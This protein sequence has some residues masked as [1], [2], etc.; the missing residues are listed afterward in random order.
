MV[1]LNTAIQIGCFLDLDTL[2][3]NNKIK[4]KSKSSRKT[5]NT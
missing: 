5:A 4:Y 3:K 2:K 1:Q